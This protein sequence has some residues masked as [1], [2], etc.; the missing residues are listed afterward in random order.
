MSYL[1]SW[2]V[3]S[4]NNKTGFEVFKATEL[5]NLMKPYYKEPFPLSQTKLG[6]DL[7]QVKFF[8]KKRSR[9]GILYSVNWDYNLM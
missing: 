5:L 4:K 7:K 3:N 6:I 9:T 1:I 2:F 8:Q